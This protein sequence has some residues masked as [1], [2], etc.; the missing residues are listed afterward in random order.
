[1]L[2][3]TSPEGMP[4]I[5]LARGKLASAEGRSQR[6]VMLARM[7]DGACGGLRHAGHWKLG[8]TVKNLVIVQAQMLF[9]F[10]LF[11]LVRTAPG[12][13]SSF[14][15]Q[16]RPAFIAYTLFSIISAPLS[17]VPPSTHACMLLHHRGLCVA[18]TRRGCLLVEW[19]G[20]SAS[21]T[22]LRT[23]SSIAWRSSCMME[24]WSA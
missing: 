2:A 12:L 24:G 14:G 19:R 4:L 16:G 10:V 1:M 22:W 21:S 15:F 5:Q 23:L 7:G 3:W 11:S 20:G 8:H 6:D 17:E 18:G 13:F 9:S